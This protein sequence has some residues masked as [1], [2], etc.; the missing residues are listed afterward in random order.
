MNRGL[1]RRLA[2]TGLA[3][4]GLLALVALAAP[5]LAPYDP[6]ERTGRP[7]SPPSADHLLGTNDIG[8]DLLSELIH[9]AQVSLLVGV[10]AALVATLVGAAVGVAAGYARGWV[11][12]VLMRAVD[13]VLALPTLP[14][15]IVIGVFAGPGLGTQILVIAGVMWAGVAREL[16]SQVLSLRER[17]HIQAVRAMGA[18]P[19]HV[20]SRH[21]LPA[22]APL[23]VPQ[24]VLATKTAIL[25]EASL[26]FLGL[27][28]LTAKSWGTM[29]SLAHARSAFLTDA[30]LWWVLPP[31]LAIAM[32][33]LA[34]ALLGFAFE[35]RAR[36]ALRVRRRQAPRLRRPASPTGAAAPDGPP[37]VV[38][39]LT[40]TYD[41]VS[42]AAAG[43]DLHVAAGELVG[44]VGE[45]GSGKSTVAAAT[46]GLLPPAGEITAGAIRVEGVDIATLPDE[47]L[48][49]LRGN[50]IAMIPQEAMSALDP[51]HPIADQLAEAVLVHRSVGRQAAR[52]RAAEL[53]TLVGIDPA[54]GRDHPHQFSGGMRQRVVI[55]MALA[56]DPAVVIADEPTTGLDVLVQADVLALLD[57]LRSTI[58]IALLVV[59]H[60]LPVIEAVA[61][62]IVVM[63]DGAVVESGPTA[64]V[65]TAPEHPY[66]RLLVDSTL[67]LQVAEPAS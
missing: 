6:A 10:V 24:F 56:N 26:A 49:T 35:E 67:R 53:L 8:H 21:L 52:E 66:T 58:G 25:L 11:D 37:L 16:R 28:D 12:T 1:S 3:I 44:L 40:V 20:A 65:L 23:V 4:L 2:I 17:D 57:T 51:V 64:R 63:K 27:G 59:T 15:T 61:D 38:E 39:G 47:E 55:A 32:T 62:R 42:S 19:V 18:G 31:G 34:F 9:G 54:R 43:V 45:S 50:R 14:L 60:D 48:R 5:L 33:V 22:V 29:L 13:V 46:A 30:W 36:P 41:G 7:F